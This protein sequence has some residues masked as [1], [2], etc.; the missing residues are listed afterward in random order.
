M[1]RYWVTGGNGAWNST[2]NWSAS[3]GGAS[4]ASLP[5]STQDVFFD[6]NSGAGTSTV[7]TT[8]SVLSLDFTG[9]AGTLAGSNAINVF[10]NLKFAAT[11][12]RTWNGTL[13]FSATSGT[14]TV[15]S[16][17]ITLGGAV[18][19]NGVGGT[20]Q[21]Q[22]AFTTASTVTLLLLN[23]TL[24]TNGK[25]LSCGV[26]RT[27]NSNVRTLTIANSTVTLTASGGNMWVGNIVT[28][29][30]LN[31]SGSRIVFRNNSSTNGVFLF[32]VG[33]TFG[34][35]EFSGSGSGNLDLSSSSGTL[36]CTNI[37][38]SNTGGGG[39]TNAGA[40][41]C[42]TLAFN[43]G[44]T[45]TWSGSIGFS[46]ATNLTLVIGMTV[47][48][49]T[50]TFNGTSGTGT[51]TSNGVSF[52]G[53][54]ITF[55]GVGGSWQLADALNTTG[56]VTL[57]NGTFS[58]AGFP[59]QCSGVALGP[60]SAGTR[61][62]SLGAS[63]VTLIGSGT[64]W[65]VTVNPG[66]LTLNA[67]TSQIVMNE[68]SSAG[69]TFSGAGFAYYDLTLA[70]T[71]TGTFTVNGANSFNKVELATAER[72]LLWGI[73]T[74][75]T[76]KRLVALGTPGHLHTIASTTPG[77][78]ATVS[79]DADSVT[80]VDYCNVQD[81]KVTGGARWFLGAHSVDGGNNNGVRFAGYGARTNAGDT[82]YAA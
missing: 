66:G 49:T 54:A 35:V 7:N 33:L 5:D 21:L 56:T 63:V 32:G 19:F 42:S 81:L 79:K 47:T 70:G 11:M 53:T 64:V 65:G 1:A 62:L 69:K 25:A 41:T 23:G 82:P 8:T 15:T 31:A 68:G 28:N 16:N 40:V 13:T 20:W 60:A 9:F 36:S 10:G 50:L 30:T 18:T 76:L 4:G 73:T 80:E 61:T 34:E 3:S 44:Y 77:T 37:I 26:L 58:T 14:K 48:R 6:G 71:G 52:S 22:D 51:I 57:G 55:S 24:D 29:L 39:L 67:G 2:T 38:V 72:T 46:V 45:G 17:G 27:D 43:S 75:K 78:Q 12:T 59:V 74:T